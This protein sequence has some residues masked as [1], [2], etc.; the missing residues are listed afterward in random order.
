MKFS[1]NYCKRLLSNNK[2]ILMCDLDETLLTSALMEVEL[3]NRR[4][5][6]IIYTEMKNNPYIKGYFTKL[7][8]NLNRFLTNMSKKY[9]LHVMTMGTKSYAKAMLK[10]IDPGKKFFGNRITTGEE[11]ISGNKFEKTKDMFSDCDNMICVID[12]CTEVWDSNDRVI[13]I[14]P[15]TPLSDLKYLVNEKEYKFRH[16]LHTLVL[17]SIKDND[18]Y[19]ESLENTLTEIHETYFASIDKQLMDAGFST[20]TADNL[21]KMEDI[22]RNNNNCPHHLFD[23]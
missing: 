1:M 13:N 22:M 10:L 16:D 7:R 9:E 8:P 17:E 12:D 11:I 23:Q 15:Y 3:P 5:H 21:P 20:A 18:N 2:L 4:F 19:L 6:D 14:D